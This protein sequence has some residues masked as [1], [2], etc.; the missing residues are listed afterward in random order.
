[1]WLIMAGTYGLVIHD[2][3]LGWWFLFGGAVSVALYD[4]PED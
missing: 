2:N 3:A 4:L 1:M